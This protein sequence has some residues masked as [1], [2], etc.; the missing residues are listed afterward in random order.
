ME[1]VIKLVHCADI[2]LGSEPTFL[3]SKAT[4]RGEELLLTFEKLI[5]FCQMEKVDILLI[6]GDLF[7]SNNISD[8]Y[9]KSVISA[10]AKIPDTIIAIC[11]G[12]HDPITLDCAFYNN[13]L[14]DN[15]IIFSDFQTYRFPARGFMI[16]G[17]GFTSS[18]QS[19]TNFHN[20]KAEGNLINIGIFHGDI[21]SSESDKNPISVSDIENSDYDYIAL[22]HIHA[23]TE[24][25]RHDN[26]FYAYSGCLEGRGFDEVGKKGFYYGE[27]GKG[28][29]N[30]KFIQAGKRVHYI[31]DVDISSCSNLSDMEKKIE[32]EMHKHSKD[33]SRDLFKINL[34][35]GIPQSFSFSTEALV[36]RFSEKV[37]Y[38]KVIDK[39]TYEVDFNVLAQENS[40]MGIFA[41][42]MLSK[43]ENAKSEEE[44]TMLKQALNFGIK[45]SHSKL[46]GIYE[47]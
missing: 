43:I 20:K 8:R 46:G 6:A 36:A 1:K 15:V 14:S 44:K 4:L 29:N 39:T 5:D 22:G 45:A 34:I 23:R 40:L 12:N 30:L 3:K 37:F 41:K 31:I 27:I 28:Y 47:D 25:I 17:A 26:V 38:I 13:T 19:S 21:Y 32:L 9:I 11:G 33:I 18:A 35:G 2:H 16:S 7:E 10:F 42:K 24:I